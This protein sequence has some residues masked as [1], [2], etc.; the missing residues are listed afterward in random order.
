MLLY[1][2]GDSHAA[3]MDIH[4]LGN[5]CKNTKSSFGYLLAERLGYDFATDALSGASNDRILRTTKDFLKNNSKDI[6]VLIGWSTTDRRE[7]LINNEYYS[8]A[9]GFKK[10]KDPIV[11]HEFEQ[12]IMSL[13]HETVIKQNYYWHKKIY[14]FHLEL[15][16]KNINHL[17]FNTYSIFNDNEHPDFTKTFYDWNHCMIGPYKDGETYY[18]WLK[19]NGYKVVAKNNYHYGADA[20][21]RWADRLYNWL[22]QYQLL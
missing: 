16:Q 5:S 3:G 11:N 21:K 17:F 22:T 13:D 8:F 6:F 15:Q 9:P 1:V 10:T 19:D 2:N 12:Y 14:N 4:D 20:H 18:G 7:V